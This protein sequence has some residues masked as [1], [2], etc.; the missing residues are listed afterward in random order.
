M[1]AL[2]EL[3]WEFVIT[4]AG[5]SSEALSSPLMMISKNPPGK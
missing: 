5:Y 1:Q 4:N 2:K 3:A